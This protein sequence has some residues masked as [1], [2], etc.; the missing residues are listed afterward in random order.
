MDGSR[1]SASALLVGIAFGSSLLP[2]SPSLSYPTARRADVVDD[3]FGTKVADPYRWMEDLNSPELKQWVDAENALAFRYLNA[4]PHR[5]ALQARIT[6]LWNYPKV[7]PPQYEGGHWFYTRNTALQRQPVVFARE[8]L[9][10]PETVVL[11][12]NSL[13]PDGSIAL[14]AFV[15][16]PD[17]RHFAY[18]QSQG[19]SDW[20]TYRVRELGTGGSCPMSF[21]G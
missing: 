20:S 10:G 2:Q 8:V 17:G 1:L 15:P 7:T 14:S 11:D 21:T 18:G 3:Y 12:P 13:S 6:E 5:D 9:E 19:G 16:A 4:L